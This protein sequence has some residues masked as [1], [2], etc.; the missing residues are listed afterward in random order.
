MLDF[1]YIKNGLNG[2]FL[3]MIAIS[4]EYIGKMFPCGFQKLF[5]NN[6]YS[7]YILAFFIL[8]VS[9]ILSK[10]ELIKDHNIF[11]VFGISLLLYVWL[12]CMTKMNVYFFISLIIILFVLF[13]YVQ[14]SQNDKMEEKNKIEDN[15]IKE[16]NK[17]TY[18]I[19]TLILFILSIVITVI[20]FLLYYGEKKYEYKNLFSWKIFIFDNTKC[21]NNPPKGSF[22]DYFLA[23]FNKN[24]I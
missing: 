24:N 3:M 15:Q 18:N 13:T 1:S 12:I 21:N 2:I 7:K 16:K 5:E 4:G 22:K 14:Y 19:I 8:F 6:I 9:I 23:I 17:K 11:F 20:G 10:E